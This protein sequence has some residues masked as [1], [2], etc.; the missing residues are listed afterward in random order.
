MRLLSRR[1]SKV[2][3]EYVCMFNESAV[4]Q[5]NSGIMSEDEIGR[6]PRQKKRF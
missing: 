4:R 3:K 2:Q 6:L 5:L 1:S